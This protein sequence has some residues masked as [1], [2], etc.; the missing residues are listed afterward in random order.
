MQAGCQQTKPEMQTP[1][2]IYDAL[3]EFRRAGGDASKPANVQHYFY[4][5]TRAVAE[6]A[7]ERLRGLSYSAEIQKGALGNDWLVLAKKAAVLNEAG[8]AAIQQELQGM[9]VE[10]GGEYDGWEVAVNEA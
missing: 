6:R 4:F 8:L 1:D 5:G 3:A 7:S 9:A 2:H 10:L